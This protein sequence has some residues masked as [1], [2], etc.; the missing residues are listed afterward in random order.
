MTGG[1]ASFQ[2]KFSPFAVM[3]ATAL[4]VAVF[5]VW[6]AEAVDSAGL[7]QPWPKQKVREFEVGRHTVRWRQKAHKKEGIFAGVRFTAPA[8]R[9]KVWHLANDYSDVGRMTPGILA[10]RRTAQGANR[11]TIEVDIKVLWKRM[12]L[13]FE[14]EREPPEA[15]HL[16]WADARF[17]EF[18][19]V[20]SFEAASDQTQVELSTHFKPLRPVPMRLLLGVERLAMMGAVRNFLKAC[21]QSR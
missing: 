11:E 20:A 8:G 9:E 5:P 15:V 19:G 21:E 1:L 12:T 7:R 6:A 10:V 16:R 13:R 3:T 14:V 4:C 2:R 17:G 18:V